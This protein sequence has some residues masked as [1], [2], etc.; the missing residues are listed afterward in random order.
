MVKDILLVLV[1]KGFLRGFV[2]L[3]SDILAFLS[4]VH[5]LLCFL[6][7]HKCSLFFSFIH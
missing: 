7:I 6:V 1:G 2:S 3:C 4:F 5:S